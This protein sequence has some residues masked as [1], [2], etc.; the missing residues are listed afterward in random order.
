MTNNAI[1]KMSGSV[2]KKA[3][4]DLRRMALRR[5]KRRARDVAAPVT[6]AS[7]TSAIARLFAV[8]H[9][10]H[11]WPAQAAGRRLDRSGAQKSLHLALG[12]RQG[13]LHRLPLEVA[14]GHLGHHTLDVDLDCD[15]RRR[16][17]AGDGENLVIVRL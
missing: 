16:G 11:R 13:A 9:V 17:R 4:T 12:P 1:S 8:S 5:P 15:F 6:R 14:D 2:I 7:T 10:S 3:I